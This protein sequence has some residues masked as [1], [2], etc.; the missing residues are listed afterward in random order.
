MVGVSTVLVDIYSPH[1]A[2]LKRVHL[3]VGK[4]LVF[5]RGENAGEGTVLLHGTGVSERHATLV[6][7]SEGKLV[8]R[9]HSQNGTVVN[10]QRVVGETIVLEP[11]APHCFVV[12]GFRVN[13]APSHAATQK[14][15]DLVKSLHASLHRRPFG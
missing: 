5:G 13:V 15:H 4:Q 3:A 6:F 14:L 2:R 8:L 10:G 7:R 12:G 11:E 1:G 9:D